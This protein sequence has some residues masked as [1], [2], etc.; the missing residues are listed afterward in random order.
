MVVT[1]GKRN[2][3]EKMIEKFSRRTETVLYTPTYP[4]SATRPATSRTEAVWRKLLG[5]YEIRRLLKDFEPSAVFT[6]STLYSAHVALSQLR[7]KRTEPILVHL[8]GD[9]WREYWSWFMLSSW[10]TRILSSQ[11][12]CYGWGGLM[13]AQKVLPVCK[14][15]ERVTRHNLPRKAIEVVY[16]GVDPGEFHEQEGMNLKKP[17]VAII[18]NHTVLPK[19]RGLMDFKRVTDRLPSIH[20]YIAEGQPI[21]Q[22][23]LTQVKARFATSSNVHFV[24]GIHTPEQVRMM[25]TSADCYLLASK[26]DCCPTTVLE[27]SLLEKPVLASRV[28]G[29]PEIILDGHTG[30]TIDN[31]EVQEWVDKIEALIQDPKLCR[32]LGSQGREWVSEKFGWATI[33]PQVEELITNEAERKDC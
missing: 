5:D 23:Y 15:L 9:W 14:W 18:Q 24:K 20:F 19:A 25:L 33:A 10:R 1:P 22:Q 3:Y 4:Y 7:L 17:A 28:G 32:V 21:A 8:L 6:D 11:Q 13:L 26:L 27:A 29:V 12:F 16:M 2:I 31:D 30:W